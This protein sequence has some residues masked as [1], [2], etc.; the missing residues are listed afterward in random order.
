MLCPRSPWPWYTHHNLTTEWHTSSSIAGLR[1]LHHLGAAVML[2]S[3]PRPGSTVWVTFVHSDVQEVPAMETCLEYQKHEWSMMAGLICD[4]PVPLQTARGQCTTRRRQRKQTRPSQN[5]NR[6]T[7][8]LMTRNEAT[9]VEAS[10]KSKTSSPTNPLCQPTDHPGGCNRPVRRQDHPC[11]QSI[12][13]LIML[14]HHSSVQNLY[15]HAPG[16]NPPNVV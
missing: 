6:P 16:S 13:F 15:H 8:I 2:S 5:W 3:S 10:A 4:L 12:F 14:P 9:A 11:Q 7:T 1:E